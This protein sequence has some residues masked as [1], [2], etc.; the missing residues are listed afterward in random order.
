MRSDQLTRFIARHVAGSMADCLCFGDPVR[1]QLGRKAR[2]IYY[3]RPGQIFA[4]VWWRR[5]SPDRQHRTLAI[6]EALPAGNGSHSAGHPSRRR[7][8]CPRPQHGPAGQDEA[9]DRLLDLIEDLKQRGRNP[10]EMPAAFW[11]DTV[12]E[13]LLSQ[14]PLELF[15]MEGVVCRALTF[16]VRAMHP[17]AIAAVASCCASPP[18]CYWYR[19][20]PGT[21]VHRLLV[22]NTSPSVAPGLY[23]RLFEEP[24]VG[25]TR[26]FPHSAGRTWIMFGRT[27]KDGED[28]YILKP[29]AAGPGD[30]VDTTG[31]SLVINGR[32]IAPMPPE[33]GE[34]GRFRCG[35]QTAYS[36]PD[37]FFVFSNRIPNSF[38]SRCYG[39][40]ERKD[41]ASVQTIANLV[42]DAERPCVRSSEDRLASPRVSARLWIRS[43]HSCPQSI[44]KR[45]TTVYGGSRCTGWT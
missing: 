21:G 29:I 7:G 41:I 45:R 1:R 27:G 19:N 43:V 15:G 6:V 25:E 16:A 26:G 14:V 32:R 37:E 3:F 23:L 5:Y 38:D 42:D 17:A 40:I 8:P 10:A 20:S 28:W 24:A 2:A 4:V 34:V 39:P 31:A 22:I 18:S 44:S 36:R 11:T 12:Q 9:V 13:L 33:D 30:R 35:G